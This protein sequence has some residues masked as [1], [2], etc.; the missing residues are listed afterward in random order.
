MAVSAETK[1]FIKDLFGNLGGITTRAMMGGLCI[2]SD[3]QIFAILGEDDQIYL[4]AK[5]AFADELAAEGCR[6]FEF[7]KKDGKIASMGYWTLPDEALDDPELATEWG[8]R[9]L[10]ANSN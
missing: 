2:Y 4:K 3:G 10:V 9:A 6:K 5:G 1:D 7:E 8:R